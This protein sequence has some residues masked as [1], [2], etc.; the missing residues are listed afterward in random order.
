MTILIFLLGIFVGASAGVL[1]MSLLIMAKRVSEPGSACAT[2]D[3]SAF[4]PPTGSSGP[5]T[6]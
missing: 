4:A 2:K 3:Q 1:T 5:K 6:G